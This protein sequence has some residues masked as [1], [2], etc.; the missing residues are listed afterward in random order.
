[1]MPRLLS[2]RQQYQNMLDDTV[3]LQ[4]VDKHIKELQQE[5]IRLSSEK[6]ILDKEIKRLKDS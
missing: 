4:T 6:K 1:M 5:K 2:I 3:W